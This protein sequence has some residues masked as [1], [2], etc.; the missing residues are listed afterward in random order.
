MKKS[1]ILALAS[2]IALS[3]CTAPVPLVS[4]EYESRAQNVRAV[5]RL[6]TSD[7]AVAEVRV[8][9]DPDLWCAGSAIPIPGA[10]SSLSDNQN[11]ASYWKRAFEAE[12]SQAGVLN[13]KDP[14][15]KIYNLID[16][17]RMIAEPTQLR[18]MIDMRLFSSNGSIYDSEV[19]YNVPTDSLKNME[20]GCARLADSFDKAI[21]WSILKTLSA[22]EFGPL[23]EPGLDYVPTMKAESLSHS[24]TSIVKPEEKEEIWKTEPNKRKK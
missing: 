8:V 12:L 1:W 20:D 9:K 2:M 17:V 4:H 21:A 22:P 5:N 11:I 10:R 18:W 3:A 13:E 15:V 19:E 23:V 24:L 6:H 7:V 16:R 14:K